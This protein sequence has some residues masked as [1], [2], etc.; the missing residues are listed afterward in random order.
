MTKHHKR[1]IHEIEMVRKRQ[2]Y[3][4]M[5]LFLVFEIEDSGKVLGTL[6]GGE[7]DL[8]LMVQVFRGPMNKATKITVELPIHG[9]KEIEY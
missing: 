2:L 9:K 7:S 4:D 5:G 6:Y 3:S 8:D 1:S